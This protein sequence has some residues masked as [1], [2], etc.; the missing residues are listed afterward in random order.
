MKF[1]NK[2]LC[3]T[4]A[5]A[6]LFVAMPSVSAVEV[7]DV[8]NVLPEDNEIIQEDNS[9][10]QNAD[11]P[12]IAST[13]ETEIDAEFVYEWDDGLKSSEASKND[14]AQATRSTQI[15][16]TGYIPD[17]VYA[18]RN[19]ANPNFWMDVSNDS[20]FPQEYIQ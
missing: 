12:K 18:L 8:P 13:E 15:T 9:I 2:I 7:D 14:I 4:L 17:G 16:T 20:L 11:Q 5:I 19:V 3:L 1:K 10:K 6:L